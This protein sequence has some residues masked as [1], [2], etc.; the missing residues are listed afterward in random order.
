MNELKCKIEDEVG[1]EQ[2]N[3]KKYFDIFKDREIVKENIEKY[4]IM[5]RRLVE[6]FPLE[7]FAEL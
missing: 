6:K 4:I 2:I 1:I 7:R 5:C 3:V